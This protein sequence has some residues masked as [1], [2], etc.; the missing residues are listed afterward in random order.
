MKIFVD[1]GS[2]EG[3]TIEEVIKLE[4]GFDLIFALE[5]M[6]TQFN[7]LQHKF[8]SD[9]RVLTLPFGLSSVSGMFPMF[10]TNDELEASLF[11]T[12][13]DVDESVVTT[14]PMMSASEFFSS[15]PTGVLYCNMNCEGAEVL[16][17]TDLLESGAIGKIS[18]LLVDFDIR[19]VRGLELLEG[20]L[21]SRLDESGVSWSCDWPEA[22]T[23]QEQVAAWLHQVG[24]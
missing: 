21:R 11:A 18:H 2:H 3:Q 5:P 24:A 12:K 22:D 17:L 10:G 4:W 20:T 7:V 16:I 6:P 1:V 9:H 8:G 23:H 13:N 14:A 19:K 15:M